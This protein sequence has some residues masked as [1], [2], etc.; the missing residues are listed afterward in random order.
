MRDR[1]SIWIGLADLMLCV[2]SV[3]ITAVAPVKSKTNGVEMKAL[4]LL[5]L[6]WDTGMDADVDIHMLPPRGEPI[7]YQ[8]R[9]VGCATLDRDNRGFIDTVIKL[10]DGSSTK[11]MS[12]KETI[13]IR[14]IEPGRYDM[15]ANLYAYRLNNLTQGDRHDL[16][17]KVHAE[18][19]RLNPKVEPVFAKDV[20]LDWVGETIN[21]VS[22]DMAQDASISLADPPLE[23]ITAKYQQR[24]ARGETP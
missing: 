15:A 10:P 18:I 20:T 14:C 17:I 16:G 12:N 6:E 4:Y 3:V 13:A 23:P 21:V 19:V 24:K 2:V 11:V 9:D 7:F 1:S 5:T 22:F 8:S